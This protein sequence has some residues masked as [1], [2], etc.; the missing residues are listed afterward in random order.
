LERQDERCDWMVDGGGFVEWFIHALGARG[1]AWRW[2]LVAFFCGVC[3]E[4]RASAGFVDR[5]VV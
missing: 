4:L 2:D 3:D 5:E 1:L